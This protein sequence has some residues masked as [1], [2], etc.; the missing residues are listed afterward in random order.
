[1]PTPTASARASSSPSVQ[2]WRE[3]NRF[4]NC[5]TGASAS[6]E[7]SLTTGVSSET[8]SWVRPHSTT[9]ARAASSSGPRPV[10]PTTHLLEPRILVTVPRE[11]RRA[12]SR[13]AAPGSTF[14]AV[15][16]GWIVTR[17]V[18]LSDISE[19]SGRRRDCPRSPGA[20][21]RSSV[22]FVQLVC[23]GIPA[24]SR[25]PSEAIPQR[26]VDAEKR[27]Q[28]DRGSPRPRVRAWVGSCSPG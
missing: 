19:R 21:V 16:R 25:V 24:G 28:T 15:L 22:H 5:F 7:S 17:D 3:K 27:E 2:G 20:G 9:R 11:P 13:D 14:E 18:A 1:M 23:C 26:G 4:T 6:S 10:I 8:A 12:N